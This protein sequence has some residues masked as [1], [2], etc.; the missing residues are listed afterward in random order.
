[1]TAESPASASGQS[2]SARAAEVRGV[3]I[4][5]GGVATRVTCPPGGDRRAYQPRAAEQGVLYQIVRDHLEV[6]LREAAERAGR[7]YTP[8]HSAIAHLAQ[9]R[10][11]RPGPYLSTP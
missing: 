11:W 7:I 2:V 4:S 3:P 10:F 1:M 6:F 9:D 8:D 5:P